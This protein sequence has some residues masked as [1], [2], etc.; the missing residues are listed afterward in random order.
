VDSFDSSSSYYS[1]GGQYDPF[2]RT[3]NALLLTDAT[4]SAAI[5]LGTAT[6]YGSVDTGPGVMTGNKA[7]VKNSNASVGDAAYDSIA[8]NSGTIET[9]HYNDD[10]NVQINDVQAPF[11]YG[12]GYNPAAGKVGATN[13]TYVVGSGNYNMSALSLASGQGMIVTG[14][15]VVY[16]NANVSISSTGFIYIAPGANLQ[17]YIGGVGKFANVS[18]ISGQAIVNPGTA[19]Q[20]MIYGLPGCTQINYSGQGNYVGQIDAP[21]AAVQVTGNGSLIGAFTVNS[22]SLAGN[23]GLHY[24]TALGSVG[25]SGGYV[26]ISWNEF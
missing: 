12:S 21:E 3:A 8:Q 24:D 17:L 10:A 23:G 13:Y 5:S 6:V 18:S 26:V 22:F 14:N 19:S 1:T 16:V 7:T 4:N 15:A 20:M 25:G 2:K 11:A 9:G